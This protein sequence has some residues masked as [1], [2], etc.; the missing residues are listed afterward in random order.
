MVHKIERILIS[1]HAT[2]HDNIIRF[3][4]HQHTTVCTLLCM[5]SHVRR[6]ELKKKLESLSTQYQGQHQELERLRSKIRQAECDQQLEEELNSQQK[7]KADENKLWQIEELRVK[8][9]QESGE[10]ERQRKE[11]QGEQELLE[12]Q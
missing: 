6:V 7:L 5:L 9:Q 8:G 2:L 1:R 12:E 3:V 4:G 11:V 10:L